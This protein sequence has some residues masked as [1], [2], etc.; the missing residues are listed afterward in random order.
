MTIDSRYD[1]KGWSKGKTAVFIVAAVCAIAVTIVCILAGL[2]VGASLAIGAVFLL[3]AP[4]FAFT[5]KWWY[6]KRS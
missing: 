6:K 2:N 1:E 4:V 3:G 5:N